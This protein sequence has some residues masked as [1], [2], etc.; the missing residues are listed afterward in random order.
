MDKKLLELLKTIY[1][2][3]K[4][5]IIMDDFDSGYTDGQRNAVNT[6]LLSYYSYTDTCKI[7]DSWA[8]EIT[9]KSKPP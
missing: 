9:P 8:E 6:I 4:T 7:Q 1:C 2:A 5:T 3:S